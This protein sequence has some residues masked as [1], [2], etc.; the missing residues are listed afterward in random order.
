MEVPSGSALRRWRKR[1]GLTQAALAGISGLS[2]SVIAKVET[3]SV[4]PR[5]STLRR[6]V[7]AL[8]RI[9]APDDAHTVGDIMTVDLFALAPTDMVQTAVERMVQTGVSQLPVLSGQTL[10]GALSEDDLLAS[11]SPTAIEVQSI[12][13]RQPPVVDVTTSVKEARRRLEEV[14]AL[15]VLDVGILVGL[16]TRIDVIRTLV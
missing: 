14:D 11:S 3:E 1:L 7:V 6:L 4:D 15:W 16:V 2:Q 8:Q 9:E 5:A 12:M 13:R 10:L